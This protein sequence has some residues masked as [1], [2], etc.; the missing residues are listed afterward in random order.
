MTPREAA[1]IAAN[2]IVDEH[3]GAW[4][5]ILLQVDWMTDVIEAAIKSAIPPVVIPGPSQWEAERR[6]QDY[7]SRGEMGG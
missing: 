6:S 3:K 2:R 1:R 5:G 7:W 4:A